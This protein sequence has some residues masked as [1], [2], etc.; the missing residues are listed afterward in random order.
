[1]ITSVKI[2]F[3]KL[4]ADTGKAILIRVYNQEHWLPKKLC[5]CLITNKKLSGKV[6]IPAWLAIDKGFVFDE[7]DADTII[8]KHIPA[9]V[10]PI[11]TEP[12]QNLLR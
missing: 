1:M 3:D 12:K 7:S 9:K 10:E 6:V 5:S 2:K 4:L 8:E 11:I